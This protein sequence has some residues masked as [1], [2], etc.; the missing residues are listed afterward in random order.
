MSAKTPFKQVDVF[1]T[2]PFAG[3]P[4]AV[5]LDGARLTTMQMQQIANWTNLSETTFVL[6][7]TQ[8]GADY[9]VRIFTPR[10]E[11][12]FAGH[13][14]IG[15]AHALLEGGRIEPDGNGRLVQECGAGLVRLQASIVDG[16]PGRIE[17]ELPEPRLAPPDAV[18]IDE[19]DAALGCRVTR[20]TA[21]MLVDVGPRWLV[22]ELPDAA[23]VLALKPD[24]SAI[25]RQ[26]A[27]L[28]STGVTVYGRHAAGMQAAI[29]VR[30]FAPAHGIDEDPVCGS[31]TGSV[32]AFIRH[33]GRR[34]VL[35]DVFF[36]SQGAA[37]GRSGLIGLALSDDAIRVGG[38]ART[39]IEGE[40][41]A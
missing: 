23:A 32:G 18:E 25:A 35:G 16:K 27:R 31:G 15:T 14:T 36:A 34:A 11:L 19:L 29:E 28:G 8:P 20:D 7:A 41:I 1:G 10:A 6:P 26:S 30:A 13:P 33:A 17:F 3:N 9:R 4:V 5:I 21:P 38:M 40:L 12:P 2:A 24:F 39:C 22:A 37:L